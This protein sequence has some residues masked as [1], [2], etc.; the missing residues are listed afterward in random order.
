VG[1][2]VER[3]AEETQSKVPF[4]GAV[5]RDAD[6]VEEVDDLW[7][8][9]GHVEDGGLVGEEVAA[10]DGFVEVLPFGVALLACDVVAGVDAALGADAVGA[11]HR[12]QRKQID[13]KS[14]FCQ[15]HRGGESR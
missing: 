10:D 5:E 3:A 8:L 4:V 2:F 12:H 9:A 15:F 11:L 13:M 7:C 14:F 6:A 1:A